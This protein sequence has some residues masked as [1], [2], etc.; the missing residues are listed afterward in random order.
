MTSKERNMNYEKELNE[1]K[2]N[3][4]KANRFKIRQNRFKD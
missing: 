1:L 2:S 3:I 4:E